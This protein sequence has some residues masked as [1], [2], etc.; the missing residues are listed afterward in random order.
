MAKS[1]N[2][3]ISRR[4]TNHFPD[5]K[6]TKP[7]DFQV[8]KKSIYKWQSNRTSRFPG[9]P[10]TNFPVTKLKDFQMANRFQDQTNQ[11]PGDQKN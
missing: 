8:N 9:D 5:G 7:V 3:S 6:D 1:S 11:F 4:S 2:Q 10:I